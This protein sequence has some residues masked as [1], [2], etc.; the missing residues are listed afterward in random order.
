MRS[1]NGVESERFAGD[2]RAASFRAQTERV[3][4]R[5]VFQNAGCGIAHLQENLA[6]G[7]GFLVVAI[8]AFAIGGDADAGRE[9][10]RSDRKSTRLNSSH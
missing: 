6:D 10:E 9:R 3:G 5:V 7:A 8:V 2:L 4:Q 1:E